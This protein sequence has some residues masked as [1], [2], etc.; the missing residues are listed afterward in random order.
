MLQAELCTTSRL[1]ASTSPSWRR[2]LTVWSTLKDCGRLG[3]W[4]HLFWI[5]F[6]HKQPQGGPSAANCALL[7]E[8]IR[9]ARC[10]SVCYFVESVLARSN[11][12]E[13]FHTVVSCPG[14][15]RC[16]IGLRQLHPCLGAKAVNLRREPAY[17][18]GK[19]WLSHQLHVKSLDIC[20]NLVHM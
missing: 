3:T 12:P 20:S 9:H 2:E 6:V 18:K 8:I 11:Q 17:E 13:L 14:P 10:E 19:K 15:R 1:C 5:L 16:Q 4:R 7:Q